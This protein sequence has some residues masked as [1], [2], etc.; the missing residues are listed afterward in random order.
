MPKAEFGHRFRL[1]SI[2]SRESP[3]FSVSGNGQF[4]FD[5]GIFGLNGLCD[6]MHANALGIK[7]TY[8]LGRQ[9]APLR[10]A[11]WHCGHTATCKCRKANWHSPLK[12]I[13]YT[14]PSIYWRP[15][16]FVTFFAGVARPAKPLIFNSKA[17]SAEDCHFTAYRQTDINTSP[18][19]TADSEYTFPFL[20]LN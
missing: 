4:L 6:G 8:L 1:A 11:E 19:R 7:R 3:F 12:G 16:V 15:A 20:N 13:E 17:A 18:S 9:I 14:S 5:G 2:T 10:S